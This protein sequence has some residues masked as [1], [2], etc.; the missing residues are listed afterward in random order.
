MT[1]K[2]YIIYRPLMTEK[3]SRLEESERKYAFE[4][5]PSANKHEIKAAVEQKFDVTV[6]KVAT[7]NRAGKAKGMTIRSNGRA[8]RTRGHRPSWKRAIVTLAEG[9]KIDLFEVGAE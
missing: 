2:N 9:G 7:Q 8:L 4:V 5:H 6:T 3:M 1:I